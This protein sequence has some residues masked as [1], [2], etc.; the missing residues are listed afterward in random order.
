M[1]LANHNNRL[2]IFIL[3]VVKFVIMHYFCIV[4]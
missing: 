2:D 4:I 3:T 1:L